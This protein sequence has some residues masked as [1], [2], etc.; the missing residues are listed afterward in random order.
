MCVLCDRAVS[1]RT[2][3][4]A[5]DRAPQR[6]S[7]ASW[8]WLSVVV[9]KHGGVA[10][11]IVGP[12]LLPPTEATF[13]SPTPPYANLLTL[14]NRVSPLIVSESLDNGTYALTNGCLTI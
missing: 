3:H 2:A 13:S 8:E 1:D 9:L 11:E 4:R 10:V 12:M 14:L 6:V 5:R 7:W